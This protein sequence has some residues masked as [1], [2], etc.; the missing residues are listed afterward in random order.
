[1]NKTEKIY[2][3]HLHRM[4][5]VQDIT[6]IIQSCTTARTPTTF[7]LEGEW[8]KGKTWIIEKIADALE[9]HDLTK[10]AS[11]KVAAQSQEYLVF[12]YNAWEQDYY[13]E[14]L[15]A[16][17]ITLINQL[18]KYLLL[19]NI[20]KG[21]ITALYELS[22]DVLENALRTISKRVIGIDV[23][24]I[25]KRGLEITKKAKSA[26]TIKI[27][28]DCAENN[29]ERDI[30]QVVQTLNNLSKHIPLVFIVDELDRCLPEHAIKTLERLHHIFG[31]VD[32]SVTIISV[33]ETQLKTT[34]QK[35]FGEDI[36][37]ESYLRKFVNFR[38]SLDSGIPDTAELQIKL[39]AFLDS[40]SSEVDNALFDEVITNLCSKM[41]ARDF[42]KVCSNAMLCHSLVG[43][44]TIRFP[45]NYA[46]SELLLFSCKIA[47]E[48]EDQRA[49][50]LPNYGNS[51]KTDL[52]K[53]LKTFL[54]RMPRNE[55]KTLLKPIEQVCYI[56][57]MGLL[58]QQE[59]DKQYPNAI[60]SSMAEILDYYEEYIRFYTLI[61]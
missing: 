54:A 21:E 46:L 50:I 55:H 40:F 35:M 12:R 24:D 19:E 5:L 34:V 58:P 9:G 53:Y 7:S 43:K 33:N 45:R 27:E 26:A 42:E 31:K 39:K 22:K 28:A 44:E 1:M 6:K 49:N 16:I 47:L 17:L 10:E 56:C 15:L 60:P 32:T 25:G 3:D 48:K 59:L 36:P 37:F 8:G 41:T 2:G 57:I 18:N 13:T 38:I 20:V 11:K 14:P 29:I 4:D 61:K 30:L 52:G 23:V 51:A